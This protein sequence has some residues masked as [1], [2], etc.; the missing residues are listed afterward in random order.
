MNAT[1]K[2]KRLDAG[3]C[4]ICGKPREPERMNRQKCSQCAKFDLAKHKMYWSDRVNNGICRVCG[5]AKATMGYSTCQKC[6]DA[7]KVRN[8]KRYRER[9]ENHLC[10]YCKTPVEDGHT[11]CAKCM[12]EKRKMDISL[13]QLSAQQQAAR[14]RNDRITR[15]MIE[16]ANADRVNKW[17]GMHRYDALMT[18]IREGMPDDEIIE[19]IGIYKAHSVG[20][21][22]VRVPDYKTLEAFKRVAAGKISKGHVG[23]AMRDLIRGVFA[24]GED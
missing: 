16:R 5:K 23:V 13:N 17:R 14:E 21:S 1:T 9:K 3:L 19:R 22:V 4:I 12:K 6:R 20:V 24:D 10:V 7:Q 8:D 2:K 18:F 15:N 11:V